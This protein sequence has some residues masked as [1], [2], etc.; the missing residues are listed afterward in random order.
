MTLLVFFLAKLPKGKALSLVLL[1][2]T[3]NG[4]S[5]TGNSILGQGEHFKVS[6]SAKSTTKVCVHG[7][8]Q[9]ERYIDVIDTPGILDTEVASHFDMLKHPR[10][11]WSAYSQRQNEVLREVARIFAMTPNGFD[12]FILITRFGHKFTSE[13]SQALIILQQLLGKQAY[14]NMI[15]VLTCGDEAE[16]EAKEK[17]TTINVIVQEYL[18]SLPDWVQKFLDEISK[19]VFLFNNTLQP[20]KQP[21]DYKKQLAQFIKVSQFVYV[22]A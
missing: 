10:A 20:D 14:N 16:R 21:G 6:S 15:L 7:L 3:G 8:R 1:G 17:E 9:D 19:R 12:G 11:F 13:D 5:K 22:I 4:K 2:K 18:D